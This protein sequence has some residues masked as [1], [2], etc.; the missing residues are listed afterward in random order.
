LTTI[1]EVTLDEALRLVND[2]GYRVIDVREPVEWNEGHVASATLLPL[3]QVADKIQDVEPD[4]DAKLL[5]HCAVGG[6][7]ARAVAT[8]NAMGYRGADSM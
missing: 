2:E 8:L 6:R 4:R 3:G 7:S 1:K 5:V